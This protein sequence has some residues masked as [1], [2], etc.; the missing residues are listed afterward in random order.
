MYG[1]RQSFDLNKDSNIERFPVVFDRFPDMP[2]S[3]SQPVTVFA[4]MQ[5]NPNE[6]MVEWLMI[7][8]IKERKSDLNY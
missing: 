3:R 8:S 6:I 1:T 2:A 5:Y 7:S 4:E